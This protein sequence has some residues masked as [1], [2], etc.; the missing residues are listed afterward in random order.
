MISDVHQEILPIEEAAEHIGLTRRTLDRWAQNG[1][2]ETFH[3]P[4]DRKTYVDLQDVKR[5]K[6]GF[7]SGRKHR[8]SG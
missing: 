2:I 8:D 3:K 1:E 6:A 7:L 5:R 4:K